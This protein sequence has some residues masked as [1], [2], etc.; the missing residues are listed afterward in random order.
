[1]TWAKFDDG[2][3]E[4]LEHL[5]HAAHRLFVDSITMSRRRDLGGNL[6]PTELSGLLRRLRIPQKAVDELLARG[7]DGNSLWTKRGENHHIRNYEKY[8][9]LTS[10]ERVKKWRNEKQDET[11]QAVS[12]SVAGNANETPLARAPATGLE[13][14]R[15]L[16]V[17][18]VPGPVPEG[19]ENGTGVKTPRRLEMPRRSYKGGETT[20]LLDHLP[21]IAR[22]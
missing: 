4:D 12:K 13:T 10:T 21:R 8:N 1:M 5:S 9:P 14:I 6:S 11:L 22:D 3:D 7:P 16:G 18:P 2:T 20:K 15:T 17:Y 19:N